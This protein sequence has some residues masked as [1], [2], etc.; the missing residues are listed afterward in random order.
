VR[1]DYN[2]NDRNRISARMFINYFNQPPV[3]WSECPYS[4]T[5]PGSTTGKAM[6]HVDLSDQ[7]PRR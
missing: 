5:V 3:G 2:L 7:S 1:V 6:R 4:P